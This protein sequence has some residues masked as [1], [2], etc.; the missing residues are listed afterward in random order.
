MTRVQPAARGF[1]L[2]K[3][4]PHTFSYDDLHAAPGHTTPWDGVRNYQVRNMLRDDFRLGDQVFIYHSSCQMPA[5]VGVGVIVREGYPDL[6][7]LDINSPYFDDRAALKGE[8][9]WVCVDVKALGRFDRQIALQDLRLDPE[10]AG[11][12]LLRKG[13]RLSVQPVEAE[14]WR[15]I[16]TMAELRL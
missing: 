4:E 8:S 14:A 13:S 7:A 15:H 9:P 12:H 16:L 10:L 6:S 1:W 5:I 3:T 2:M 11:M